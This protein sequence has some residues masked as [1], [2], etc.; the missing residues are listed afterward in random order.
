MVKALQPNKAN[1][2]PLNWRTSKCDVQ[3]L[4]ALIPISLFM[5]VA[6][7]ALQSRIPDRT[8]LV[9][10]LGDLGPDVI[11]LGGTTSTLTK[12]LNSTP[13]SDSTLP[14]NATTR[15]WLVQSMEP[16]IATKVKQSPITQRSHSIAND[17]QESIQVVENAFPALVLYSI[18]SMLKVDEE[19]LALPK[20]GS[21]ETA[22]GRLLEWNRGPWKIRVREL[23]TVKGWLTAVEV[24]SIVVTCENPMAIDVPS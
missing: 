24:F 5:T 15:L 6:G 22:R 17:G 7:C 23:L 10:I 2:T 20:N 21:V 8:E 1:A 16:L 12:L 9:E 13:P 19:L 18:A 4:S 3:I 11:V 14:D